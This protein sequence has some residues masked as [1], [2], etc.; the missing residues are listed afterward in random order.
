MPI[1][2]KCFF[3]YKLGE[4]TCP[5]CHSPLPSFKDINEEKSK[6]DNLAYSE[7]KRMVRDEQDRN[8]HLM[9]T[10][11]LIFSFFGAFIAIIFIV[12]A[13]KL[14]T[15]KKY[16]KRTKAAIII[17]VIVCILQ[18]LFA[19]LILPKLIQL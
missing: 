5:S 6:K 1:C 11:S 18:I 14:D 3:E 15:Q 8:A 4:R 2:E 16:V 12:L 17:L 10:M 7:Y 9:A 13:F 19:S